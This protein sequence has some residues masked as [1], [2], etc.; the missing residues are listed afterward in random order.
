M[1]VLGL[2]LLVVAVWCA[3]DFFF[4]GE[5]WT[6][7]GHSS[8]IWFNGGGMVVCVAASGYCFVQAYRRNKLAKKPDEPGQL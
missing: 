6:K 1:M 2:A 7:A 8:W 4:R 3:N 5:D